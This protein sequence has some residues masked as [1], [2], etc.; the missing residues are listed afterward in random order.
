MPRRG[1]TGS[2]L[3]NVDGYLDKGEISLVMG[4]MFDDNGLADWVLW[5][6]PDPVVVPAP[7]GGVTRPPPYTGTWF[8]GSD[9]VAPG[10]GVS[11]SPESPTPTHRI[12]PLIATLARQSVISIT[13]HGTGAQPCSLPQLR[14]RDLSGIQVFDRPSVH[15]PLRYQ[16]QHQVQGRNP[17]AASLRVQR[18]VLVRGPI[19][20]YDFDDETATLPL[21]SAFVYPRGFRH[22]V[23]RRSCC[24]S[25]T[26]AASFRPIVYASAAADAVTMTIA[27]M[28]KG[29]IQVALLK[30]DFDSLRFD[31]SRR[32]LLQADSTSCG[33]AVAV[34]ALVHVTKVLELFALDQL[35]HKNGNLDV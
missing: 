20:A 6:D 22:E 34:H 7:Y 17:L 31:T 1:V 28:V 16:D 11:S 5:H 10:A 21:S 9:T 19:F 24:S 35:C 25:R 2:L 15:W 30:V 4:N 27:D 29:Y 14:W 26:S 12:G 13:E 32:S 8:I 18:R 3:V 23:P 33:V